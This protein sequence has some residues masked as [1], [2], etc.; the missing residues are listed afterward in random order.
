MLITAIRAALLCAIM[1]WLGAA[2]ARA[3][4]ADEGSWAQLLRYG[5]SQL[6]TPG[7]FEIELGRIESRADGETF[8]HSLAIRDDQ[9]VWLAA[10][11]LSVVWDASAALGGAAR[12]PRI[13]AASLEI[14]RAPVTR[15]DPPS[16]DDPEA[17]LAFAWPRPPV[18]LELGA[19]EIEDARLGAPL[20]GRAVAGRV[21]AGFADA[22]D[23]QTARLLL[24]RTDDG[25]AL[26][27]IITSRRDFAA[28]G[29]VLGITAE[30]APGGIVG[31]LIG[32]PER[33]ALSL[34]V[35][36]E[37][38]GGAAPLTV[39][40]VGEGALEAEAAGE[41]R[42]APAP[43]LSLRAKAT[44]GPLAGAALRAAAAGGARL[45]L[46]LEM[47]EAGAVSI[48]EASLAAPALRLSLTGDVD[49]GA[50]AVALSGALSS[51]KPEALAA[52]IGLETL[53]ALEGR[54]EASGALSAPEGALD[55][56]I[57]EMAGGFGRLGALTATAR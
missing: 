9:G 31:A 33:G 13:A 28:D 16:R 42:W 38:E 14:A 34:S 52:L 32:A 41:L 46:D 12:F 17:G 5:V 6:N 3:Q 20:L 55:L 50:D 15:G 11:G 24:E 8:I 1:A 36:A 37:G 23:L 44:P 45:D 39:S 48:R 27:L 49:P 47:D 21:S 18:A 57:S 54:L 35:L 29:A 26:R 53:G 4:L 10:E 51:P 43:A 19:L 22:G 40:A 25:P 7:E 30:E 56:R 2:P